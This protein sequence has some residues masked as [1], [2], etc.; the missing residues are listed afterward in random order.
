DHVKSFATIPKIPSL[1]KEI[2]TH[3][4]TDMSTKDIL[5]FATKFMNI[6]HNNIENHM[7]PGRPDTINGGSYWVSDPKAL[8]AILTDM[9]KPTIESNDA[10]NKAPANK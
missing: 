5:Y 9:Q 4:K 3:V 10:E 1:I 6:D 8:D 7:V 2:N